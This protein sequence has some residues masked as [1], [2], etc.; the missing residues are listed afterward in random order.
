MTLT[1]DAES[2]PRGGVNAEIARLALA[3]D[4]EGCPDTIPALQSDP[5]ATPWI[6]PRQTHLAEVTKAD[7]DAS[8]RCDLTHGTL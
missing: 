1:R 4:R 6:H 3:N 8:C 7:S 5:G 2:G